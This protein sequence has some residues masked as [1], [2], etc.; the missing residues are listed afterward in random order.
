MKL[1]CQY[2][3]Q[4]QRY[5]VDLTNVKIEFDMLKQQ[6]EDKTGGGMQCGDAR[7]QR[8]AQVQGPGFARE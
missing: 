3:Y 2:Q 8:Q 4:L 1:A 5:K 7:D 6:L